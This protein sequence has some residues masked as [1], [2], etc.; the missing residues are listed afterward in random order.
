MNPTDLALVLQS[1][2]GEFDQALALASKIL[3]SQAKHVGWT[4]EVLTRKNPNFL[5][6]RPIKLQR[7]YKMFIS[8]IKKELKFHSVIK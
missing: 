3:R 5:R 2:D 4:S 1:L 8:R 7:Q 6:I